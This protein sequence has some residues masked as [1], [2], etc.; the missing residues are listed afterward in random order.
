MD[1]F[2]ETHI[3]P[4]LTPLA[5]DPGHP[6][7][8]I[9]NLSLSLAVQLREPEHGHEHFARVKVPKSLARWVPVE[10]RPN[11]FVPL[12]QVI[13]AHLGTLFPGMQILGSHTFRI[14]RYSD[15]EI[16]NS[17]EP[18]DLLAMIE[19]QVFQRRFGEVVR[20]E[21][22]ADMPPALRALLL[23]ELRDTEDPEITPLTDR[24]VH[25][26]G[27]LL[28]LGDLMALT[29]IDLPELKDPPLVPSVPAELREVERP[30]FD[31]IRERDVLVHHPFD[32]FSA[33]VEQFV[34]A[35]ARDYQTLAIK[36]TLYRTGGGAVVR[37]LTEAAQRGIQV[38]VLVELQA[39]FEETNNINFAR[40]LESF[41]VHVAYGLQGLK[42]HAKV[43]LVVRREADGIRRYV[44]ISTGNYNAKTAR[45]YT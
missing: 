13:G 18:E 2:F 5:V 11:H 29:A 39:R 21:V 45:V 16:A 43:A 6:F 7:P 23:D 19:E 26:P 10:G 42:T 8:Y 17:E 44:H 36:M 15:L 27:P 38:A 12:E 30:I 33:S 24:E 4:V 9:S 3:F 31:A 35:A 20:L 25:T 32:S 28:D 22:A 40:T 41:G 34:E 14:T 1:A 37:A